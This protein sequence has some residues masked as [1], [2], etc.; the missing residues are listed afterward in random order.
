LTGDLR[1]IR[2]R[3]ERVGQTLAKIAQSRANILIV[4]AL[5][6][7]A[8]AAAAIIA[9]AVLRKGGRFV[10]RKSEGTDPQ[11]L[12]GLKSEGF[13]WYVFCGVGSLDP[14][15]LEEN[16]RG[17]WLWIHDRSYPKAASVHENNL[18][19]WEFGFPGGGEVSASGMAYL[20]ALGVDEALRNVGWMPVVGGLSQGLDGGSRRLRGL[21]QVFVKDAVEARC[22][23]LS[24]GLVLYGAESKA[25]HL[26]LSS[27]TRPF[28]PILVANQEACLATL[29]STGVGLRNDSRWKNL[30]DL[31]KEEVEGLTAALR[32]LL[33]TKAS[34]E[35]H[36]GLLFGE[37]Y[38]LPQE[39]PGSPLR[40]AR[41]YADLLQACC[42]TGR[43]AE[44]V[45]ICLGARG[46]IIDEAEQ[47]LQKHRERLKAYVQKLLRQEIEPTDGIV[48]W[49]E[50]EGNDAFLELLSAA[51]SAVPQ[52]L[53]GLTLVGSIPR[54][55]AIKVWATLPLHMDPS[56]V[57]MGEVLFRAAEQAEG[58]GGGNASHGWARVPD[59]RIQT[60]VK[61]VRRGLKLKDEAAGAG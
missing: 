16:L 6:A 41:E 40:D 17:K 42:S 15:Q 35:I 52:L 9:E 56:T 28:L 10:V 21:A 43:L 24:D 58:E 20:V 53:G 33:A 29:T 59:S 39:E 14:G 44:A 23:D 49:G 12:E 50:V 34:G 30:K 32:P 60:F 1:G 19:P 31:S 5:T 18:N 22:L 38:I 54:N 61:S 46:A 37:L 4:S 27:T 55:E 57:D 45:S 48:F 11:A 13:D 36:A 2:S 25:L 7:D 51:L 26:A 47:L 3:A 8:A